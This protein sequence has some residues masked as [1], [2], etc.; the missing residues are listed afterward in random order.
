MQYMRP[1]LRSRLRA[2]SFAR[3]KHDLSLALRK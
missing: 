2:Y 1:P 3:R